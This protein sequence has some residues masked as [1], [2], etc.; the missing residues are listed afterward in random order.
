MP[1]LSMSSLPSY[2]RRRKG[3]GF[4]HSQPIKLFIVLSRLLL[5]YWSFS[6]GALITLTLLAVAMGSWRFPL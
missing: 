4:T 2:P 3:G 1:A 5:Q 6:F